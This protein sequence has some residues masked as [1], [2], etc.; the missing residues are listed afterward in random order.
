MRF[1]PALLHIQFHLCT[2]FLPPSNHSVRHLLPMAPG[3]PLTGVEAQCTLALA[4][5]PMSPSFWPPRCALQHICDSCLPGSEWDTGAGLELDWALR[6]WSGV[7]RPNICQTVKWE[8][9]S[10]SAASLKIQQSDEK[11]IIQPIWH[12]FFSQTSVLALHSST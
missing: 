12:L 2:T 1:T 3:R 7:W 4:S 6:F 10:F 9:T 8:D 5:P 11:C